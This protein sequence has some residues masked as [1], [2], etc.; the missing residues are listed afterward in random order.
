[1]A[2]TNEMVQVLKEIRDLQRMH[3]EKVIETLEHTKQWVLL[4]LMVPL[5]A[6]LV[7]QAVLLVLTR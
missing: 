4:R 6:V 7:I 5:Y 1:M 2:E 3:H